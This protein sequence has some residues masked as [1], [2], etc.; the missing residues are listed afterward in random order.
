[1]NPIEVERNLDFNFQL[2]ESWGCVLLLDEADVFLA[3]R[4]EEANL[5]RNALVSSM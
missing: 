1:M 3:Q 5:S 2:V 4:V